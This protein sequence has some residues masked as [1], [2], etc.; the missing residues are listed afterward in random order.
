MN[1]N[2][3]DA[4]S[5]ASHSNAELAMTDA[6]ADAAQN[7]KGMDGAIAFHLIDRHAD[8]WNEVG[9]MM[10]AWLRANGGTV[11]NAEIRGGE[12]VPLD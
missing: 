1:P 2:N 10:N 8:N 7:W 5:G 9:A 3:N 12:A 4:D 11:A 6:E